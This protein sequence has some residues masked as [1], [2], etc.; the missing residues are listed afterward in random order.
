MHT[1]THALDQDS[2]LWVLVLPL[3]L[4]HP[5][6]LQKTLPPSEP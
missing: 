6:T 2:E 1:L 4:K 5:V 3:L